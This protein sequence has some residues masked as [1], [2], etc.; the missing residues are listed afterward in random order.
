MSKKK[1]TQAV[2][3]VHHAEVSNNIN[4]NLNQNDLIDLAIQEHLE[5]LE[6][7]LKA[8][9][10]EMKAKHE[11][12][13]ELKKQAAKT[14][15]KKV[16]AKDLSY[17]KL[18]ELFDVLGLKP[19]GEDEDLFSSNR[20]YPPYRLTPRCNQEDLIGK[21]SEYN[22][23]DYANLSQATRNIHEGSMYRNIFH[24]V[25]VDLR[26]NKDAINLSYYKSTKITQADTKELCKKIDPIELRIYELKKQ[27]F[28]LQ[29][30]FFEYTFG[31]KRVKAKIVKAS[32]N[33]TAEGQAILGMLQ[34]ATGV[35]LIG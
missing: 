7:K 17:N 32:L 27:K 2:A 8:V 20:H 29:K 5:V 18:T 21:Y 10:E 14:I 16:L 26:Y 15:A 13:E 19:E 33:K 28:D 34:G 12:V 11:E 1:T 23:D 9:K 22:S 24:S 6:G 35:K 30:E 4:L 3:V 31:E 25:E